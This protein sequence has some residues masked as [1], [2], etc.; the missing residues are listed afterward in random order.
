MTGATPTVSKPMPDMRTKRTGLP[1]ASVSARILVVHAAFGTADGLAL[2]PLLRHD[3][4]LIFAT[5][6]PAHHFRF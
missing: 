3:Q 4:L 1:S 6:L 5:S 2:V